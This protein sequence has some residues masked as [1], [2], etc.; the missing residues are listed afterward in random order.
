M[1]I[2]ED[3]KTRLDIVDVVSPYVKLKKAGKNYKGLCPF[4]S[5]DTP[6]FVVSPEKGLAYCFGCNRGGDIYKFIQEIEG[7]DFNEALKMLAEK[8]GI[9]YKQS[10]L[11]KVKKGL[12]DKMR[13]LHDETTHFYKKQL[14]AKPDVIKYLK[15]ERGLT[16]ATIKNFNFGYA[17]DS[18][19]ETNQYL[20]K[21]GF[22]IRDIVSSGLA[23]AKDTS[24]TKIYDR[25]RNRLM[26]PIEDHMGRVI[27]FGG[28]ILNPEDQPKYLNSPETKVYNKSQILY[29]Y[30]RAK[31][32]I[33]KEDKVVIVE[34]YL[35]VISSNQAGVRNVVASSGTALTKQQILILKRLTKNIVLAF[36]MD[37]AGRNAIKRAI[38]IAEECEV[39]IYVLKLEG[40]KDP[41]ECIKSDPK[42]WRKAI[43]DAKRYTDFYFEEAF[44]SY[45][46]FVSEDRKKILSELLPYVASLKDMTQRSL[47]VSKIASRFQTKPTFVFSE[48][49]KFEKKGI[50]YGSDV[51]ANNVKDKRGLADYLKAL[52]WTF[53]DVLKEVDF[54]LKLRD[55][56]LQKMVIALKDSTKESFLKEISE[57]E[58]QSL[59]LLSIWFDEKYK[60]SDKNIAKKE[61]NRVVDN[62][63][64][65]NYT[66]M[67]TELLHSMKRAKESG[68]MTEYQALF[69][70]YSS[71]ITKQNG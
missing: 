36:D 68:E 41:D 65:K 57:E 48:L 39:N 3:I 10:P 42:K 28:R 22:E 30:S 11:S 18:F 46:A 15:E 25:F 45:D 71:L 56:L 27:A 31:S 63:K 66:Q 2:V 33:Q 53:P 32:D 4:H 52:I 59:D 20:I 54:D 12:K 64:R 5:E 13:S 47:Y 1:D 62:L 7:V 6:S 51:N 37:N 44:S 21:K 67:Q 55:D 69:E 24:Y 14:S 26:I 61:L 17:P 40:F 29:G 23:I 49:K 58:R 70:K 19:N 43:Q 60:M 38:E 35:D 16:D 9:E 50:N 34:G 8:A